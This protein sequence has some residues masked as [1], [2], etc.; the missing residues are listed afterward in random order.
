MSLIRTTT[1]C[2]VQWCAVCWTTTTATDTKFNSAQDIEIKNITT[3]MNQNSL[4]ESKI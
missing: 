2:L 1:R 4:K 3:L